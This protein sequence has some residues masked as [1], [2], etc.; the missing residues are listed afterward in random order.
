MSRLHLRLGKES[1]E[2]FETRKLPRSSSGD[3]S[4]RCR[5]LRLLLGTCHEEM[6]PSRKLSR[7]F[8]ALPSQ[9][10]RYQLQMVVTTQRLCLSFMPLDGCDAH[11][12]RG[13][14]ERTLA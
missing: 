3:Q 7:T 1:H 6:Y 4:Q 12:G 5:V 10:S 11:E 14:E 13:V 9:S 8:D 2:S